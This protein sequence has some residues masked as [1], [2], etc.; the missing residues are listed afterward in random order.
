LYSASASAQPTAAATACDAAQFDSE[1]VSDPEEKQPGTKHCPRPQD[2]VLEQLA[3]KTAHASNKDAEVFFE[4]LRGLRDHLRASAPQASGWREGLA[5]QIDD[6]FTQAKDSRLSPAHFA[7]VH[8]PLPDRDP[9]ACL[10]VTSYAGRP[11]YA[12]YVVQGVP[13]PA[14]PQAAEM[15]VYE[16]SDWRDA[17]LAHRALGIA[18]KANEKLDLPALQVALQR[19][20]LANQRWSNLRKRGYLQYPWELALSS[21]FSSYSNYQACFAKDKFCTGEEGLD[22]ER[23]RLIALH[24]GVGMGFSGFG[25][26]QKPSLDAALALSLELLGVTYYH[27]DFGS[28]FGAS[29]GAIVND[30]DFGDVRPGVFVHVTRWLHV[31]YLMSF[32]RREARYDATVFLSTDLGSALGLDFLEYE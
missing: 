5:R 28:Y 24:P 13:T 29:L 30:G 27:A 16:L 11:G 18:H 31:G 21:V 14:Q 6:A 8:N 12:C 25:G 17:Y 22:P 32:F 20:T 1:V 3:L 4:V 23:V 9:E 19:L 2:P 7:L 26:K 15:D 10:F